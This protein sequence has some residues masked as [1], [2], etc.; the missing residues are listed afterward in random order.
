[1]ERLVFGSAGLVGAL[2]LPSGTGPWPGVVL[3][4]PF[5]GVKEQVVGLYAERLTAEGFATLAFD[6]RGFGESG[7]R[8]G[9]EDTQGKLE[10]L[11]DAVNVLTA[12]P[13]VTEIAVVGICLGGGYAVRAA[14]SDPRIKAVAGIAGAYNS[15]AHIVEAMGVASYRSALAGF[16]DRYD[17]FLPAV[18]PDGGE[19]AMGGDEPYAYYGTSRSASPYWDGQVTRGSLHSLMTFDALSAA[20]LLGTTPLLV[21]HGRTDAYCSPDLARALHARSPGPKEIHWL[22]TRE[23]IDLYDVEPH[24]TTAIDAASAFLRRVLERPAA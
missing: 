20:D 13:D 10:D 19:A 22:D 24:V 9:H 4:G 15:P 5:T 14:A 2:R 7:G 23:H 11:R 6:H 1:M 12:R 3:T 16:L 17:E 21:V 8:R 18:A